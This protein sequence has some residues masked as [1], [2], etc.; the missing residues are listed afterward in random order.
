M[1]NLQELLGRIVE[2]EIA[3]DFDIIYANAKVINVSIN[4]YYFETKNEPIYIEL[5]LSPIDMP[6]CLDI[7]D[8]ID[9]PLENIRLVE[10]N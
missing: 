10:N 9:V 2:V 1:N 7:E 6:E 3:R 4:D 8:F 5:N